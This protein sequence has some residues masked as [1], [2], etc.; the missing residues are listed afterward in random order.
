MSLRTSLKKLIRPTTAASLRERTADLRVSLASPSCRTVVAG[1]LAVAAPMPALASGKEVSPEEAA[2]LALIPE[3]LPLLR[4]YIPAEATWRAIVDAAD[5]A[6]GSFPAPGYSQEQHT[7]WFAR[8][9][10]A[11]DAQGY[12]AAR[13]AAEP[14]ET[15]L[16][17]LV[18]GYDQVP[19]RTLSAILFKAA[20]DPL[21]D[22]WREGA[23]ADL[24]RLAAEHFGLPAPTPEDAA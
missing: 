12:M 17:A 3:A 4:Q 19:M 21:H 8:V 16:D 11:R 1:P 7:A 24:G 6:A 20:L 14:V 9:T 15:A 23:M 5:T 2:F 13:D 18:D 22:G 10:A